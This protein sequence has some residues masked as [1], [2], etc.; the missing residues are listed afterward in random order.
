MLDS[1]LPDTLSPNTRPGDSRLLRASLGDWKA[2][3]LP[4]DT[5]FAAT[6][7]WERQLRGIDR[8]WLCWN[9]DPAWCVV[10][11]KQVLSVGWT[12]VVGF[13]PRV[14]PPPILPGAIL[15][16]FNRHFGLPALYPHVPL[17]FAFRFT[18]RLAFWHSDLIVRRSKLGR[19]ADLFAGLGDGEMAAVAERGGL[20]H[21]LNPRRHRYWELIGCTTR[22]ASR[23]QFELGCG[24]WMHFHAHPNV[25]S[26][27]ER[28]IRRRHYWDHGTGVMYWRRLTGAHVHEILES[29]V[30]EGHCSQIKNPRYRRLTPNNEHRNLSLDLSHNYDLAEVC[31][32]LGLGHLLAT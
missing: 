9:V 8:P 19:L 28:R 17:E 23:S 32:R 20:R 16:D 27:R 6:A 15:I 30:Q 12:P 22:A 1:P 31:R 2:W 25:P 10:Q 26:E 21:R 11:Q 3:F 29:L 4:L 5:V 24:W 13:D 14:G 7:H 18:D